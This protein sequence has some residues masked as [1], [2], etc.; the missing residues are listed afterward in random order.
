MSGIGFK[1]SGAFP[2]RECLLAKL[3]ASAGG[4]LVLVQYIK[5]PMYFYKLK[6]QPH[7]KINS[8]QQGDDTEERTNILLARNM[9]SL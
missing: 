7:K 6:G 1:K 4:H 5:Q 2:Q 8:I 9:G 3:K